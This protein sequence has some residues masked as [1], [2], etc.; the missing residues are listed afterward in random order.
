MMRE[1]A[2]IGGFILRPGSS[3]RFHGDSVPRTKHEATNNF[4]RS[5]RSGLES[6]DTDCPLRKY[7]SALFPIRFGLSTCSPS[8]PYRE[9]F[10]SSCFSGLLRFCVALT[11]EFRKLSGKRLDPKVP[12]SV[13]QRF[14]NRHSNPRS[15]PLRG[16]LLLA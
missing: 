7:Q 14:I 4:H 8:L 11:I 6:L 3:I 13:F 12:F 10:S 2:Q 15:S 16:G 1:R 5:Q 9:I